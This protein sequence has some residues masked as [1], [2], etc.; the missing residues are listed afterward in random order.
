MGKR[1]SNTQKREIAARQKI[2]K[3]RKAENLRRVLFR[4]FDDMTPVP[5]WEIK[6]CIAWME[7][8]QSTHM[9][10]MNKED[11]QRILSRDFSNMKPEP[12][13]EIA[14]F[15]RMVAELYE[16]RDI[17]YRHDLLAKKF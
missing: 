8:I 7:Q 2:N 10:R 1:K 9:A 16:W 4:N 12:N 17:A 11:R 3:I 15:N 5:Q 13:Y 6:K 14:R